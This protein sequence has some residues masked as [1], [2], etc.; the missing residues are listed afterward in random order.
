MCLFS[1]L[2]L[3]VFWCYLLFQLSEVPERRVVEPEAVMASKVGAD[4]K[5]STGNEGYITSGARP[6][7]VVQNEIGKQ[8]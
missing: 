5:W 4:G 6:V 7:A 3:H 8:L 2:F 1:F